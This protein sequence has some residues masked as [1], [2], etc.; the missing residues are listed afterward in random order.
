MR[1]LSITVIRLRM[2]RPSGTWLSP[3]ATILC[4]GSRA[5]LFPSNSIVPAV[6]RISPEIVFSSVV[7]PAPFAP[8]RVTIWPRS[9]DRLTSCSTAILP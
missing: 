4:A 8:I 5:M 6:G 3:S 2:A 1:R 7:L 9:I